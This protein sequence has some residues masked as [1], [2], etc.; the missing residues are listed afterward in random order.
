MARVF[1]L[2]VLFSG[3]SF[4][5]SARA[6]VAEPANL[7]GFPVE[8]G[9]GFVP[10][11][12][13]VA[14]LDRN[15]RAELLLVGLDTVVVVD[16]AG[17]LTS[18]NL[19]GPKDAVPVELSTPPAAC[20]LDGDGRGE[21]VAAAVNRKLYAVTMSGQPLVGFP[22]QLDGV[23]RGAVGCAVDG[24]RRVAVLTTDAG[25]LLKVTGQG[26]VEKIAAVGRG[27]ESGVAAVD[28]DFD[29]KE[30]IIAVG[31]DARLYVFD[32][33]GRARR[34]FPYK[35]SFRV[36]GV[37]AV[38]DL[39]DDGK[40]DIAVGS[41]DF[42]IHAV[43]RDGVGLAGFPVATEYR[44]YAGVALADLDGDAVLDLVV[45]SGDKKLYAVSLKGRD[46]KGFPVKVGE[47]VAFDAALG[48]LDR[49]GRLEVVVVS[50]TGVPSIYDTAGKRV[51]F[52]FAE[53][54]SAAPVLTD[55]D[56]DGLPEVVLA[57]KTGRVHA[58]E[59]AAAGKAE[60]ALLGWPQPGHDAQHSGR[61]APNPARFK[62]LSFE[63]LEVRTADPLTVK[64]T[65]F[66]LDNEGEHNTQIR[67]YVDDKLVPELNNQRVV[68][69]ERTRKH[70]H[71]RYTLQEGANFTAYG[72]K[73]VLTRVFKA[74]PVEIRNTAPSEPGIALLPEA[75]VT[76]STLEAKVTRPSADADGDK[77]SYKFLWLRDGKV[78]EHKPT[79]TRIDGKLTRK[80]EEWRVVVTPHD[81]EEDGASSS[82]AQVIRN[83][84]PGTPVIDV[85][86]PA[87]KVEDEVRVLIK[88][89]APDDDADPIRYTYQVWV[90]GQL[91]PWPEG[92]PTIAPRVLRKHQ[93]VKLLI[94]AHDDE[95]SGGEAG[96]ELLVLNTPPPAPAVAVRP[97]KP[98]T[99]DELSIGITGQEPDADGDVITLHHVWLLDGQKISDV[100]IDP[101]R[102]SKGQRWRLEVTPFDGEEPGKTVVAETRV[103]NT[104]PLPPAVALPRYAFATHEDVVPQFFAPATDADN[105]KVTLKFLWRVN[106]RSA[107]FPTSKTS[108]AAAE[109]QRNQ[110]WQLDIVPNDGEVDGLPARLRFEIE[111]S[112]PTAPVIALSDNAPTTRDRVTVH[113]VTPAQDID[114]DAL[115]YHHRWLRDGV[116]VGNWSP[117]KAELE[118]GEA[119][120]GERWRV[121]VYAFDGDKQGPTV[122]A[123]LLVRNHAPFP[124]QIDIRAGGATTSDELVCERLR[125]GKDPDDDV[126][127][128]HTRWYVDGTPAPV[129]Q[130]VE[131]LPP[132][133][134]RKKQRWR[135]EMVA[136]DG[137]LFSTPAGSDTVLIVNTPPTA[138]VVAISPE[139]PGTDDDLVCEL[140]TPS[141]D[142]DMDTVSYRY[143]WRANGKTY[144]SSP[145]EPQRVAASATARGQNW[146]CQVTPT[147]G[148][149]NGTAGIAR[150]AIR[151]SPPLSPRVRVTP[152]RPAPGQPLSC[153]IVEPSEDPDRDLVS[154]RYAWLRDG[155]VQPFA[156]VSTSVPG[157]LVKARDM[158]QCQVTPS[159][160][161][162]TG[163]PATS[164]DVVV[165][166]P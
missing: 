146:E 93:H 151:N 160:K 86:P 59:F 25:S 161:E 130:E 21:V 127:A 125:L 124:P 5:V 23:P 141:F 74:E 137:E 94:V 159:D 152:E 115:M 45:G 106:G 103:E 110:E 43:S 90:D 96:F 14:D 119:R 38:G 72:E 51:A 13:A 132:A 142:A 101:A 40:L 112:P 65:F 17:R 80:R 113:I 70:E 47:R 136:F 108:L 29:G 34:G 123:E 116:Q 67:W 42:K 63:K 52:A 53:T 158:W 15:G 41:Q 20:D 44:I 84:P 31:G 26:R 109:T 77:V 79:E 111:N 75:A 55:L 121:E 62:D 97:A 83:T 60:Q 56:G 57:S 66:D 35:M 19:R 91:M 157:R 135:C 155:A 71:W 120:K 32:I 117:E 140:L 131:G 166:K 76:T 18:L 3:V 37:P 39:D 163:E 92:R 149:T 30:E 128:Y 85:R 33:S 114:D 144:A 138:P 68:P 2:G 148:E 89:P 104:P 164:Q 69:P 9:R 88:K 16:G 165:A 147:D 95:E 48:D 143:T 4:F 6:S 100:A 162:E 7:A 156:P 8:L 36:S 49:D 78:V 11:G 153:E 107:N 54:A 118:P 126:L 150:L 99:L 46:L 134:T 28:V 154:Y 58:L 139:A 50:E 105:D 145:D 81:G 61:H 122:H 98:R 24:G 133:L 27:A 12:I 73:G 102:T 1:S 22:V 82:T 87:P 64:Y 129:A 10:T